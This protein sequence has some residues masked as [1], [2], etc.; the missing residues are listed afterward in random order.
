[1]SFPFVFAE[2]NGSVIISRHSERFG[3]QV[4]KKITINLSLYVVR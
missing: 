1:M 2:G 4:A 3:A